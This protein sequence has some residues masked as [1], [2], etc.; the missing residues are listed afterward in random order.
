MFAATV[1]ACGFTAACHS[2]SH[3]DDKQAVY[4]TLKQNDLASVIVDQDRGNGVIKLSGIVGSQNRKDHAQQL[5]QQAA[6]GY[7]IDNQLQ[8]DQTNILNTPS[9]PSGGQPNPA[10]NRTATAVVKAKP[11]TPQKK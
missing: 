11:Q 2:A 10:D 8:V 9:T 3:P 7:T 1:L 6:P 4:N 5:A